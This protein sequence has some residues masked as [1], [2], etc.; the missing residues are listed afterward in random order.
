[1]KL[2][3]P[4]MKL[5]W[6]NA[7]QA[8][9]ASVIWMVAF[10]ISAG[11]FQLRLTP[12]TLDRW[13]YPFNFEPGTRPVAPTFASFDSRFDTRDAQF[14]IGWD[15]ASVI[16][17]NQGPRNYLL[18]RVRIALTITVDRAF[19]YD[20]TYDSF[21][22]Y[23]TNQPDSVPD[24]DLGRPVELYGVAYRG[25]FDA[26]SFKQD[27]PYG[28]LGAINSGTIS[29][30]TRNAYAAMFDTNGALIDIANN[31]G[32]ANASWTNAPFEV[33]PWAVGVTTNAAPGELVPADS[34]FV[35]DLNLNDPLITGYIQLALDSGRL[36]FM[37]SSLSPATQIT[38]GG[39]ANGGT[40]AYPQWATKENLLYDPPVIEV[41]GTTVGSADT[42]GDGLPD[43]WEKFYFGDLSAAPDAD[44][45]G[46]GASNRT[47]LLSGTNPTNPHSVFRIIGNAYNTNGAAQLRFTISSRRNY[48]VET[49]DD[50]ISWRIANGVL[51]YPVAG[52][53]QWNESLDGESPVPSSRRY[54]RVA[55]E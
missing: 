50:L 40:V 35:F 47:E 14:L 44:P 30:G 22:T 10:Q 20:P 21:L 12:P 17:T 33:T 28:P 25:G 38:P 18:K 2:R 3:T 29:I 39:T 46:D 49:S 8:L 1:M 34:K 19:I 15:T 4:A 43:D 48:R 7:T 51:S 54:F 5:S 53:A 41:E 27:S 16:A 52:V 9:L 11:D 26:A 6:E 23:T 24:S 55:A 45:D 32:Q 36:R 31:V 13:V 37:V 42:D